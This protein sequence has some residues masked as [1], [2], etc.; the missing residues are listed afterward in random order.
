MFK[1]CYSKHYLE[2]QPSYKGCM[3]C[4]EWKTFSVFEEWFDKNYYTIE[5]EIMCID[6]DI[7]F[8]GNKIYSPETCI[9]VPKSINSMFVSGKAKR[10]SLP[11]GVSY[12][13]ESGKYQAYYTENSKHKRIGRYDDPE[14]AFIAYKE[15]RE[16]QGKTLF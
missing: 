5:N 7:L 13:S 10:G 16:S 3:V 12:D 2:K 1:R 15:K 9:F 6:K 14:D 11:I 8:K 4:E